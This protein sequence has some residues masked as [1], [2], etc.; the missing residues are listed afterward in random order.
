MPHVRFETAAV[1]PP[2][3]VP[4]PSTLLLFGA[5]LVALKRRRQRAL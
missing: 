1:T 2:A 5:G 4:E 3:L